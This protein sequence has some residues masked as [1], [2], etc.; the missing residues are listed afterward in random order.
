MIALVAA[1]R[2]EEDEPGGVGFRNVQRAERFSRRRVLAP[3]MRAQP[4]HE[5]LRDDTDERARNDVRF[6]ADV[7]QP[8]DDRR[9]IVG[10]QRRKHEVPGLRRL[11]G[12]FRRLRIAN[13]ADEDDVGILA[14]NRSQRARKRQLDF[15]VDLRLVDARDL[16]FNRILDRNDVGLLGLD[17]AQRRAERRR[18][19]AAGRTDD[20]DHAV[21]MAHELPHLFEADRR[22]ADLFEGGHAFAVI[23]DA[24]DDF[25]APHGAK[26]RH[27]EIHFVA[28]IRHQ[29]QAA[30]L[31]QPLLGDVHARHDLQARDEAFVDPLRQVH[32]FFEQAVETMADQHAFFHRLDVD[33]ARLAFDRAFDDQVDEVDDWRCLAAR[34]QTGGRRFED[35]FFDAARQGS[36]ADRPVVRRAPRSAAGR[37]RRGKR[38]VGVR[39]SRAESQRL[40]GIPRIDRVDDVAARRDDLLDAIAGLKF[41]ILD[42]A[43][44]QRIRH[45]D[46]QKILLEPDGHA[47]AL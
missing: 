5:T 37:C 8:R 20:E 4:A 34:L 17:R 6:G 33:V 11:H 13:L 25:L 44:K 21:L 1:D 15:L 19:A 16:I 9:R 2:L 40:V 31:R 23:E 22:H 29:P 47:D 38:Q 24:H 3:A 14:E 32:D 42:Q 30:V 10:V 12:D 28:V 18:L 27:A 26:R 36:F 45:R 41:E 39:L 46:R 35:L 43:E 7:G